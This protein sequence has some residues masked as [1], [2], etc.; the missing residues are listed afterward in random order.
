MTSDVSFI[1]FCL[2]VTW[3]KKKRF[4][5][6]LHW[7]PARQHTHSYTNG[8]GTGECTVKWHWSTFHSSPL[9]LRRHSFPPRDCDSHC[10]SRSVAKLCAFLWVWFVFFFF[11]FVSTL[12][13]IS[14]FQNCLHICAGERFWHPSTRV[15]VCLH[16]SS[17][18]SAAVFVKARYT[19]V[20]RGWPATVGVIHPRVHFVIDSWIQ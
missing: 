14:T 8:L 19:Q 9:D 18:T 7:N 16:K 20:T 2:E 5:G 6:V 3:E 12:G 11:T 17:I 15:C 1:C 10:R 4:K 13:V